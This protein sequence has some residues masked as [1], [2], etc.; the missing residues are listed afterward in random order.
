MK[1]T[2]TLQ[3]TFEQMAPEGRNPFDIELPPGS[4]VAQALEALSIPASAPKVVIV[5]GRAATLG[6]ELFDGDRLI[7]FPPVDGG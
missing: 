4:T 3:L 7:L 5:N 1:V 2:V 6:Q